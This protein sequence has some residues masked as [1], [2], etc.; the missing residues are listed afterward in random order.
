MNSEF[1][2]N[3][4]KEYINTYIKITST[5]VHLMVYQNDIHLTIQMMVY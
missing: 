5:T 1:V 4:L 2:D 3:V